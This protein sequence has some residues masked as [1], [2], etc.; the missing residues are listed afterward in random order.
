MGK[1]KEKIY[2]LSTTKSKQC[3]YPMILHSNNP[4]YLANC[5]ITQVNHTHFEAFII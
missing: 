3:C 5:S 1:V 2:Y 4:L